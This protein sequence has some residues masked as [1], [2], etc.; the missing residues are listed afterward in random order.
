MALDDLITSWSG[1]AYR[2]LPARSPYGVLDF[3]SAGRAVDNRWNDQR[4]PT[5]YLA[6]DIGVVIAEFGRHFEQN[7]TPTL[8]RGPCRPYH[9]SP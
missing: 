6:S 7:R 3:R 5:L 8:A 1:I 2:H 9:L 4:A